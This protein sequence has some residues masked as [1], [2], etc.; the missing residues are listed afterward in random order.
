M[1]NEYDSLIQENAEI[2]GCDWRLFKAQLYQESRLRPDAVSPVG[3]QGLGQIMPDTWEYWTEEL[4]LF[5]ADVFD[6]E[7]NIMVAAHYMRWLIDE[8]S[9]PRPGIDRHCLAMASYNAGLGNLLSAQK[10]SGN[11]IL[12]REIIE[13]LPKITKFNSAETIHYVKTILD[14]YNCQ[15][16]GVN[17]DE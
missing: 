15:I 16:I 4:R 8:W 3:A 5:D 17:L 1:K 12:Y 13:F 7:P 6:P 9:W 10:E 2:V 11:K 14:F